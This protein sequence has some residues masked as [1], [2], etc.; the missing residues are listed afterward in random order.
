MY[1]RILTT[2][3]QSHDILDRIMDVM[4]PKE[5]IL[6]IDDFLD[7]G[8]EGILSSKA[9]SLNMHLIASFGRPFRSMDEW[10]ELFSQASS[11]LSIIQTFILDDGRV[12]F[13]LEKVP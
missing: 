10:M 9:N 2:Y 4:A 8:K 12:V 3:R 7:P 1:D 11:K 13:S 6:L 5:S